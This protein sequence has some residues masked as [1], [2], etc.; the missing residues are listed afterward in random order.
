VDDVPILEARHLAL[1]Y[2]GGARLLRDV[3]LSLPRGGALALVG[4][5]G[6]G[7]STVLR[8]LNRLIDP[9]SGEVLFDGRDVQSLDPRRL[10][11][12][13]ALVAQTPVLF[14]GTVRENL[15][16]HPPDMALDLSEERIGAALADVGLPR[17]FLDRDAST[18]S[19]GEKQRATLARA[20]LGDPRV[21]LLDE[22]TSA[23]DPDGIALVMDAILRL[24]AA[25]SLSIVAVTHQ[26]ELVDRLGGQV[27]HLV[28]GAVV[29]GPWTR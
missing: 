9:G 25:R 3:S 15:R 27:V 7:K 2:P 29:E 5:S 24:R 1:T 23:L 28:A 14:A 16:V 10:R 19:G 21:L 12:D 18:L 6:S 20:V 17:A 8:C 4:P 26:R 11:R 22:P 13:V